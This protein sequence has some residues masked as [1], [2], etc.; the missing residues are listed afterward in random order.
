MPSTAVSVAFPLL[1]VEAWV[2][3]PRITRYMATALAVVYRIVNS[4]KGVYHFTSA[5]QDRRTVLIPTPGGLMSSRSF[6]LF[7]F[8]IVV[9]AIAASVA[10]AQVTGSIAGTVRD[11]SGA[12]LPGATVTVKG[13]ALQRESVTTTTSPEGTYRVPLV[14]PGAYDVSVEL[15]G[16]SAQ[17]RRSVEVAINQQT[18]LDFAMPVAG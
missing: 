15:S 5:G 11:A 9:S 13:A 12:V 18:T 8:L 14:P 10:S 16:F 2:P 7:V 4:F 3:A 1:D 6:R 17:T